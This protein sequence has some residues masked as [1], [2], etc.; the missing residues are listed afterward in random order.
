[1]LFP[2]YPPVRREGRTNGFVLPEKSEEVRLMTPQNLRDLY[3]H[4]LRDLYS[5][6]SQLIDALPTMAEK[7]SNPELQQVF[8]SHLNETKQQ[9]SRLERV[10]KNL[11]LSP[12]GQTCHGMK[13]LIKE[14]KDFL[15]GASKILGKNAPPEVVDA[16]LITA[17][18][19]IEHYEI[20]GY[21]TVATYAEIQGRLEDHELLGQ[22]LGEEKM[23]DQL[24]TRL[25]SQGVNVRAAR[26]A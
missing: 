10:F 19:R 14:A 23:A 12:E 4:Q 7:S 25:A 6:E 24:L 22:T 21:G 3:V 2:N 1:V 26:A 15:S 11:D 9:K 16:G 17:A 5:A 18:Q 8:R 13:G 20:A